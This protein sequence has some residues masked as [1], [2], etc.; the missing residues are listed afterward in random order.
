VWAIAALLAAS[1]FVGT[2]VAV[3]GL[4]FEE[5]QVWHLGLLLAP[6][7][8]VVLLGYGAMKG[9]LI[10]LALYSVAILVTLDASLPILT[11]NEYPGASRAEI[12]PVDI[13]VVAIIL[14]LILSQTKRYGRD[15]GLLAPD[16][17][18]MSGGGTQQLILLLVLL[19][20]LFL[21]ALLGSLLQADYLSNGF[22][23]VARFLRAFTLFLALATG[24]RNHRQIGMIFSLLMVVLLVHSVTAFLQWWTQGE[25]VPD[26]LV[27]LGVT[28]PTLYHQNW[29]AFHG[30]PISVFGRA[31][32]IYTSGFAGSA[33]RMAVLIELILPMLVAF[34]LFG[35]GRYLNRKVALLTILFA[36]LALFLTANRSAW[37]IVFAIISFVIALGLLTTF[38]LGHKRLLKNGVLGLLLSTPIIIV[39]SDLIT[40]R[41]T[42]TNL[43]ESLGGRLTQLT[44]VV[45]I[46]DQNPVLGI[47]IGNYGA[48]PVSNIV[49]NLYLMLFAEGGIF[50]L[51]L[52]LLPI[53]LSLVA[54]L[55]LV[56][57]SNNEL[58][59]LGTIGL[60]S[61]V[62]GY[63]L[64]GL[65]DWVVLRSNVLSTFWMML[66]LIIAMTRVESLVRGRRGAHEQ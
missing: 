34:Y 39:L 48:Q 44:E 62:V 35:S 64:H 3:M 63:L 16:G 19:L 36:L 26:F 37:L 49:H 21:I 18:R 2:V 38:G 55:R 66:A 54:G 29:F 65:V 10:N 14:V 41:F 57:R 27:Y 22:F 15:N 23:T 58:V 24:I 20:A 45:T 60:I 52:Y 17:Q 30:A 42:G 5:I 40:L 6:I 53:A 47:G 43:G 1:A 11:T 32:G 33:Y 51:A 50:A 61:G 12:F 4:P 46:I 31:F 8:V 9:R 59:V 56:R 25:G 13:A 28:K 7:P